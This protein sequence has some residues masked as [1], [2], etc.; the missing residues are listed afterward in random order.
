MII[1][2]VVS[3]STYLQEKV[4]KNMEEFLLN[5][6]ANKEKNIPRMDQIVGHTRN[7]SQKRSNSD[8]YGEKIVSLTKCE[9][10]VSK[11][12][13]QDDVEVQASIQIDDELESSQEIIDLE[14]DS[15]IGSR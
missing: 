8:Q 3:A 14:C 10:A 13:S 5:S 11:L 7:K 4:G 9:G 1:L 15:H 6:D 12:K 2:F